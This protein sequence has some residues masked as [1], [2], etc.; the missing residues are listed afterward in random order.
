MHNALSTF[1]T[2]VFFVLGATRYDCRASAAECRK[3]YHHFRA[4][5]PPEVQDLLRDTSI[6]FSSVAVLEHSAERS[7]ATA[8]EYL[9]AAPGQAIEFGIF[10]PASF[11]IVL[12]F[13]HELAVGG[14]SVN[15]A[16]VTLSE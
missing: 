13:G 15:E 7:Y 6:I 2:Y 10:G 1:K 4:I 3:L 8:A 14:G 9:R 16:P 11:W 12:L 5:G